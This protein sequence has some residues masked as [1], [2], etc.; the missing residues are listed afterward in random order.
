MRRITWLA[1][2][3][4]LTACTSDPGE[5]HLTASPSASPATVVAG[6]FLQVT[7]GRPEATSDVSHAQKSI[8]PQQATLIGPTFAA[9]FDWTA[10]V[11]RIGA[12]DAVSL[13]LDGPIEAPAGQELFLAHLAKEQPKTLGVPDTTPAAVKL[14]VGDHTRTLAGTV[15]YG[16]ATY[17]VAVPAGAPVRYAVTDKQRTQT[18]DLRTGKRAADAIAGFYPTFEAKSVWLKS[19]V[20]L[21][22]RKGDLTVAGGLTLVPWT[23]EHGWAAAGRGWLVYEASFNQII[24]YEDDE[25]VD[26][27]R[28]LTVLAGGKAYPAVADIVTPGFTGSLTDA[29]R[30]TVYFSV[31]AGTRSATI[32]LTPHGT[33]KGGC[34]FGP[35][36]STT[37]TLAARAA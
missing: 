25:K 2:A 21:D 10:T 31:P 32:K 3:L 29:G 33:C 8:D 37:V 36:D 16:D 5:P 17:I 20:R 35:G 4:L 1:A 6:D 15:P 30:A 7:S 11:P 9:R 14:T 13:R 22:P 19:E 34:L 24:G 27:R 12:E 26:V 28:S 18:L 23:Q